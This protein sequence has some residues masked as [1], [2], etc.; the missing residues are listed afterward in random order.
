MADAVQPPA[1]KPDA[2]LSELSASSYRRVRHLANGGIA[3]VSLVMRREGSFKQF[4]ALKRLLPHFR[5]DHQLRAMFVDEARFAGLIRHA[6]VVSVLDVGEGADGPYLVMEYID[7]ITLTKLLT[8]HVENDKRMPLQLVLKLC[9]DVARGLHAAHEVR[10]SDGE[11]LNLV[12]RDVSPQNVML[13]YDGV[14]RVTDFGI[15][16]ALGQSSRTATGVLKGKFGYMA[17]EQLRFE[18]PDR[19]AD[20]FALG[21]VMYELLACARLYQ[22]QDGMDGVRRILH[23]PPP[24]IMDVRDDVPPRLVALI[25]QLLA[26]EVDKRPDT[27]REVAR[28]LDDEVARLVTEEGQLEISD[29]L[30]ERFADQR[31]ITQESLMAHIGSMEEVSSATAT[32]PLTPTTR[33]PSRRVWLA[34]AALA[35]V[36]TMS[37]WGAQRGLQEL[38]T[39]EPMPNL[40]PAAVLVTFN[41]VPPGAD[42]WIAG[43]NMGKTPLTVSLIGSSAE[44]LARISKVGFTRVEERFVPNVNQKLRTVLTELSARPTA[45]A[46]APPPRQRP[47]AKPAPKTGEI[48]RI[49]SRPSR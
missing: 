25:F 12:H 40:S 16:K 17:P 18:E 48:H 22:N 29:Y 36:I 9:S 14:A 30:A 28:V 35:G 44:Q 34:A 21:V 32:L 10:S 42:V 1:A 41:S 46:A 3:E 38:R 19:R 27:A 13:G 7:G 4:Y 6:N 37:A 33:S 49:G 45:R 8:W 23:E 26:K 15:A 31:R 24:D 47:A 20:L 39:A 11:P 2:G 43:T 5:D